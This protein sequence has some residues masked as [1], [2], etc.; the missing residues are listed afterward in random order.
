[1]EPEIPSTLN[2]TTQSP[3]PKASNRPSLPD[4]SGCKT[5]GSQHPFAL[6]TPLRGVVGPWVRVFWGLGLALGAKVS[7]Q[8]M[9]V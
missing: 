6:S 4:P 2:P 8:M 9:T 5:G 3:I 1:M 7:H